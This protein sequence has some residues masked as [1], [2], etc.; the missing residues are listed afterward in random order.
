MLEND[1]SKSDVAGSGLDGLNPPT[2]A[3]QHFTYL[4]VPVLAVSTYNSRSMPRA[5]GVEVQPKPKD[6]ATLGQ[7]K[8]DLLNFSPRRSSDY[9]GF[10]QANPNYTCFSSSTVRSWDGEILDGISQMFNYS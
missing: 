10:F 2:W 4:F 9:R 6:V 5:V 3:Q 8:P 7:E 1:S